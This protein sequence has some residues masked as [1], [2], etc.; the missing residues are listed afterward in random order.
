MWIVRYIGGL[1]GEAKS[2]SLNCIWYFASI[3]PNSH[4]MAGSRIRSFLNCDDELHILV[5][6]FRNMTVF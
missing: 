6:T 1:A 2:H 5:K 4:L 3:S